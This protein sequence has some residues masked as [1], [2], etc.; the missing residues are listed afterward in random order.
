M[1]I[2][3]TGATGNVGTALIRELSRNGGNELIGV[4]RR[5]PPEI[6]PYTS[7]RW[8][9]LDIGTA[10]APD[11]LAAACAGADAVI[12][13]AWLIQPSHDRETLRRVNQGGTRAV[14]T[15]VQR[16]GVPHLVHMSSIG[17]YAPAPRG[18][19]VDESWPTSGV[20]SSS[21]S[22]DKAACE[23][24]VKG[25]TDI[26]TVLRPTLILQPDA[27]SEVARYFLGPLVPT[28]L[29]HPKLFRFAPWPR[30][31]R[32]QFVHA[33]DVAV[34]LSTVVAQRPAGAFNL[35]TDQVIDRTAARQLFGGLAPPLPMRLMRAAAT[36][37]WRLRLQP[38]DGG[39]VDLAGS[40]P[41]LRSERAR[42]E[43]GWAPSHA[44]GTTLVEFLHALRQRRGY[45][46]PLLHPR[47]LSTGLSAAASDSKRR[48]RG[49]ISKSG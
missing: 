38:V 32:L 17:A 20:S 49:L 24:I 15:A 43:L 44:G 9:P 28:S 18:T 3:I 11:R 6:E 34:A 35:A 14:V 12:H 5:K 27:A 47:R 21:Y 40:V 4:A 42:N 16:A 13:L 10:E 33:A 25:A 8:V 7:A 23:R 2:L 29:L 41:L 45:P 26:V 22:V 48:A 46:G 30:E 19:W 39:W 1:R 37:S 36:T 31:L